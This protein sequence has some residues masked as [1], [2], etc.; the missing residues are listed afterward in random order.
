MQAAVTVSPAQIPELFDGPDLLA[1]APVSANG[2]SSL[3]TGFTT[4]GTHTV[5]A[6]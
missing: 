6:A 2:R 4:D 5:T 1:T 3:T